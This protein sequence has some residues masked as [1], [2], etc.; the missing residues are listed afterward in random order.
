[1]GR[2]EASSGSPRVD[3]PYVSVA[4]HS[5]RQCQLHLKQTPHGLVWPR[6][7]ERPGLSSLFVVEP[8]VIVAVGIVAR[9]YHFLFAGDQE[10]KQFCGRKRM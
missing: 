8:E 6:E 10:M 1:M 9:C 2:R 5:R 3:D 7:R 4:G